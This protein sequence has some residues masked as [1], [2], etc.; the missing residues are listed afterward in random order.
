VTRKRRRQQPT[1]K[2]SPSDHA[3]SDNA[4]GLPGLNAWIVLALV[5]ATVLAYVP[6]LRAPFVID[7]ESTISAS[8]DWKS[9][10]GSP[11]AG[12]PLVLAT[13][14]VNSALNR[15]LG[16][17]QRPDP[18]GPNKAVGYRLFNLLVHLLTGALLFG[19]VRRAMRE[20]SIPSAWRA[21]ADPVAAAVCALWLLHPIQ[22]EV[23]NYIVQRSEGLASLFYLGV[24]YSSQRAWDAADSSRMRW[25]ALAVASGVI[26]M[27]SKEIVISAPLAVML[28]DR[29]FRLPSWRALRQPGNSRGWLYAALWIACI[30][31]FALF[32]AG[33]RAASAGFTS[34]MTWYAYFYTQCWAIAHYL[35]LV[36]WPNALSIDYGYR[37]IHGATGIPG[38]VLL[39]VFAVAVIVAWIRVERFGWFAFVGSMFFMLL[40]PSSSVVPVLLEVGAERR[41]YLALATVLV[42]AVVGAE[43]IRRRFAPRT[44]ARSLAA[45]VAA[46]ALLLTITTAARSRTYSSAEALWRSAVKATPDNS[47]ALGQLGLALFK[48]P[49]PELAAAESAFVSALALD[50]NCPGKCLEYGTL[51]SSEGRFAEA[52]PLLER[53]LAWDKENPLAER[54]LALDFM[55]LGDF[56]R[57]IPLLEHVVRQLPKE[58]HLVMLGVAYLSADQRDKAIATF[59]TMASYDP[60]NTELRRLSERLVEGVSHP[61]ALANMQEFA[62]SMARG[63]M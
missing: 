23:I 57:A 10:P 56:N 30:G 51:L 61:D 49:A 41:I 55:K 28:Y 7:D 60:G 34:G 25:Y 42:L 44:P 13:L 14:A 50:S 31:T 32:S 24:L 18:D 43:W 59:H 58:S 1:G 2:L 52:V 63:W 6:A 46:I 47:R 11:A 54:L 38:L 48:L 15:A 22:S 39:G 53:H 26:G 36:V 29:A 20:P 16:V 62:F 8:A 21:I 35:R 5:V 12:R 9:A 3:R 17:D 40:A 45:G 19:V 27:M 33:A 4:S 37:T